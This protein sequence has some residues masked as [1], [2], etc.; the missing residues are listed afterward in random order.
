[1]QRRTAIVILAAGGSRR[2]GQP[3]QLLPVLGEPLLRRVV[4]MAAEVR[5][6]H[7]IVVL[8]SSA[9]ECVPVI[10]DC[11]AD[12][13]VNPFWESGLAGSIRIGVERAEEEKADSVLLLL[14]DQPWLSSEVIQRFLDRMRG[15]TDLIISARY[16]GILGAP[17]MFGSD[18]FPRLKNLEGDQGARSLVAKEGGQ[19]EVI[20]WSEGA[21]DLDTPEDLASLMTGLESMHRSLTLS[22]KSELGDDW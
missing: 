10:K 5:P 21:L 14:A 20:D 17:M 6:D 3:K 7:L 1:M 9:G 13:V 12:I 2:L 18:W 19:V 4:K 11:D 16:N 8:G 22:G 15:Q